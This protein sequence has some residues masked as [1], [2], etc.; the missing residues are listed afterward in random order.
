MFNQ[1][2]TSRENK[3]V[4]AQLT[5]KL[6]LGTENIIARMAF[7]YSISQNRKLNLNDQLDSGGKE[8][9]RSVLFGDYDDVYIGLL[10]TH[11]SI[12]K[13]DKDLGRY[14][15]LHIDDGLQLI[16]HELQKANNID[17]FDFL[18]EMI[19]EKILIY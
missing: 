10:C 18:V 14:V 12:Y 17:G 2:R 13:T 15:K 5:R 11:Y 4:V 3:E 1:I 7:S 6:N 16:N 9:S 8:Y 19:S